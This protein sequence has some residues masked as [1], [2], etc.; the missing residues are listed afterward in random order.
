VRA[1]RLLGLTGY[2]RKF[3]LDYGIVA[4][5]LTQLLKRE[6]F[7]W[8]A[9]A[10]T[11]FTTLKRALTRGPTLQ[12]PDF[13][14]PFIVNCDASGSGFGAVLHQDGGPIAFYSRPVAPQHAKLV[15]Y[16]RELISLV[17]AVKH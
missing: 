16:E 4:R 14:N 12:L 7:A 13:S 15:A 2:Y 11:A 8:T 9:D 1:S 6:A 17:K 5:P 10:D 3:I